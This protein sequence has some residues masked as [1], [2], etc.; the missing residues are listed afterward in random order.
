MIDIENRSRRNNLRID[1]ISEKKN[2]TWDDCEPEVQS[3]IKE[4]LRIAENIA[5]ERAH[6]IK[7]KETVRI[8]ENPE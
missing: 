1:G 6:R 3:L 7:K 5:I 2:K 8:Q 4:K